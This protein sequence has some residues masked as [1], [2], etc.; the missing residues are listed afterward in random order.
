V[1]EGR[2]V[3][4]RLL[5]DRRWEVE[6]VL[7]SPAARE[8]LAADLAVRD[9]DT[10]V[11]VMAPEQ[12][13]ALAGYNI[14]RGCLAIG[15]RRDVVPL[16]AFLPPAPEPVRLLGLEALANA[17]NV[18]ACFRNAVAFGVEGVVLDARCAD[19]LYRKAIRTSM[20]ATLQVPHTRVTRWPDVIPALRASGLIVLGLTPR[21]DATDVT[22]LDRG[23]A[24]APRLLLLAGSEGHG[25]DPGTLEACDRR[26]RIAMSAGVDSLN[27]ATAVAIA[28]HTL[29]TSDQR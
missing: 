8:A 17:D 3:V 27:V 15:K 26:V 22:S 19:P 24:A 2:T 18:G 6:S 5:A 1:A 28:L 13:V 23:L 25:L 16:E 4:A 12:L 21:A 7:V 20:A 14:H 10:A 11:F 29:A 9:H